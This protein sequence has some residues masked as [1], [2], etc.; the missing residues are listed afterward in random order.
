M[1]D[2]RKIKE[3][4]R[5]TGDVR[6]DASFRERLKEEFRS[7]NI[8]EVASRPDGAAVRTWPRLAWLLVPA[9]AVVVLVALL[10]P[11][12][13]TTWSVQAIRGE[14][15]IEI[16]GQAISSGTPELVAAAL[17]SGAR[18]RV[19]EGL[20]VDVR[21][22]DVMILEFAGGTDATVPAEPAGDS[23][24]TVIGTV[25]DGELRIKTGPGFP[26]S[27]LRVMTPESLTVIVGTIVS[28][29]KG[30][31]YT[32][33][34]VLEGTARVGIDDTDL[35][36]VPHD[37]LKYFFEDGEEPILT[38]ISEDHAADLLEFRDRH[39]SVFEDR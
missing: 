25:H 2:E 27:E 23:G 21:L 6:A 24:N 11:R 7:G 8:A 22:D 5:S 26:G 13:A 36:D 16:D 19:P 1:T 39:E 31:G 32:C 4:I 18:I 29:Y 15:Q 37:H 35:E 20:S 33:V 30:D 28:V 3:A 10:V 14:G 34:C 17:R 9:A 12:S 38:D